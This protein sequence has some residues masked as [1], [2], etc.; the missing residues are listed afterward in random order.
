M[1]R[2]ELLKSVVPI[3]FSGYLFAFDP[4]LHYWVCM[5]ANLVD[6]PEFMKNVTLPGNVHINWLHLALDEDFGQAVRAFEVESYR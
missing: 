4:R 2:R 6:M 5:N 1:N 3:A